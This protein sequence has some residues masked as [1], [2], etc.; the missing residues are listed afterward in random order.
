MSF[1]CRA[2]ARTHLLYT[3]WHDTIIQGINEFC[4]VDIIYLRL[5]IRHI[6]GAFSLEDQ[7]KQVGAPTVPLAFIKCQFSY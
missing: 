5:H 4:H 7:M 6:F 2:N 3:P 1:I